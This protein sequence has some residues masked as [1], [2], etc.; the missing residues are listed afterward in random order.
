MEGR[1]RVILLVVLTLSLSLIPEDCRA[2]FFGGFGP[3][4]IGLPIPIGLPLPLPF[5][6]FGPFGIPF[7][8]FGL[9]GKRRKRQ[10]THESKQRLR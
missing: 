6:P 2:Q 5:G 9:F 7:G 3:L 1:S 4:P 8:R 10:A